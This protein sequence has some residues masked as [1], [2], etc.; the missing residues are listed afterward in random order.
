MPAGRLLGFHDPRREAAPGRLDLGSTDYPLDGPYDSRDPDV[1]RAQIRAAHAAGIDGFIVSWW[2][3]ESEEAAAFGTLLA[4]ARGTA[5]QLALYYETGELW[6]RGG[7]GVAA[8]LEALLDRY[9]RDPAWLR[10]DGAPVIF[11]YAAHRLRPA[12]WE[13]VLRRLHAGGRRVFLVG[14]SPR[15]GWI[16]LCDAVR[17]YTPVPFLARGQDPALVYRE[18]AAAAHAAG[19]PFM[20]A[21][22]PGFDDRAIRE[23]G[24]VV[25]RA[26][27]ALYDATWRAALGV[28]PAWVLIASWN[29]W[30]EGS[31]IEPSREHGAAY[32]EATRRW[33]EL[34][35]A[36]GR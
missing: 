18:R 3:R 8:D 27:G 34:F 1:A 15:P 12:V 9:G 28:E 6:R 22:A 4:A 5:V 13:Y 26:G 20:P 7:A 33:V 11:A 10:V 14:D 17:L 32:L 36:G 30:H 16:E 24:T 25:D 35:R 2:G 29:E 31:E 19:I 21:V 23:P